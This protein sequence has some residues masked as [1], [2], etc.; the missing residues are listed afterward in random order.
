MMLEHSDLKMY[1]Y[2]RMFS[3]QLNM[4]LVTFLGEVKSTVAAAAKEP[5]V[6]G[7]A[8]EGNEKES[9]A[10]VSDK[11]ST[12]KVS[13]PAVKVPATGKQASDTS[14]NEAK[15]T[16]GEGAAAKETAGTGA[17][18]KE[19]VGSGAAAKG[20]V[21]AGQPEENIVPAALEDDMAS[22]EGVELEDEEEI[23]APP[24]GLRNPSEAQQSS[25]NKG[26]VPVSV[27]QT[28]RVLKI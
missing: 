14:A 1:R 25:K 28:N 23:L 19:T 26:T 3:V 16:A 10:V 15:E 8:V 9:V 4:F 27:M 21:A 17:A 20:A 7:S 13:A 18:A 2:L 24:P 12:A 11:D 22:T 5:S 6:A